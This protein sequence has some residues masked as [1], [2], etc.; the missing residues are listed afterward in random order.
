MVLERAPTCHPGPEPSLREA[1]WVTSGL[2]DRLGELRP[3][4]CDLGMACLFPASVF[5]PV[6]WAGFLDS[7]Q[8]LSLRLLFFSR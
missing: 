1:S 8:G 3:L 5:P 6:E 4:L 2:G 7:S